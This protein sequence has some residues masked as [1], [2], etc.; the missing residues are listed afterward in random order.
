MVGAWL[1][2]NVGAWLGIDV[3]V[4]GETSVG[5][6]VSSKI[7]TRASRNMMVLA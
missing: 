1:G 7:L 4:R 3:G 2:A 5:A 6:L